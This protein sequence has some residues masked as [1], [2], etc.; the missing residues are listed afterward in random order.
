MNPAEANRR[1][2]PDTLDIQLV[3]FGNETCDEATG[4]ATAMTT[5]VSIAGSSMSAYSLRHITTEGDGDVM[6]EG[7]ARHSLKLLT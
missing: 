5:Q 4:T 1:L 3:K 6:P 7:K 2:K